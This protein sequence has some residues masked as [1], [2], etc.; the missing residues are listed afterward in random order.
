MSLNILCDA[1]AFC[2]GPAAALSTLI[3]ELIE[4]NGTALTFHVLA[5][6][7]TRELLERNNL[8][9][10][11]IDIDSEDPKALA[12][13]DL[14]EYDAFIDVCN[15]VSYTQLRS[16]HLRTAYVDFLLW[17]HEGPPSPHFDADL[18]LAENYPGT[19]QW[20]RH[21]AAQIS[22]LRVVPPIIRPAQYRPRSGTLL[23]GLGGLVSGLTPLNAA[24]DYSIFVVSQL[25]GALDGS[26]FQGVTVACG[27]DV[28]RTMGARLCDQ[29][30]RFVS[31]SHEEFLEELASCEAFVSHPGLY[32]VFEAMMGGVPTALLPASNYT[33][34]LQM[35]HYRC[36]GVATHSFSCEDVGLPPISSGLQE[37]E[38]V[39]L[40]LEQIKEAQ[41]DD[42]AASELRSML[43]AFL[44]LDAT[45]LSRLGQQQRIVCSEF[46]FEG[47]AIAANAIEK[48]LTDAGLRPR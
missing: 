13:L 35:R 5:T 3:D 26:R 12:K 4:R 16:R 19:G 29:R 42:T 28:A 8:R 6:G 44:A 21:R 47:P 24:T 41:K 20:V 48:W 9:P 36:I 39:R 43:R 33:Q 15:P 46:G 11:L 22:N 14:S 7:S 31:L 37:P 27:E 32:A 38:G 2:Y 23:V 45:A 34:V 40:T 30:V 17:M 25:L 18:Y 1:I 10:R